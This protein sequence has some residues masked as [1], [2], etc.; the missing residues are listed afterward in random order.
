MCGKYHVDYFTA[1]DVAK[2]APDRNGVINSAIGEN[3]GDIVPSMNALVV[4]GN[5]RELSPDIM[6]WGFPGFSGSRLLINARAETALEKKTFS[7][8]VLN[9]R[10]V[11]PAKWFYE[12]DRDRNMA[13]FTLEGHSTI[14]LAGF[15]DLFDLENRYVI[16][17][18]AANES[19]IRTHDRMPLLI[20][21]TDIRDWIHDDSA[22][23][24]FLGAVQPQLT[25]KQ[26]FEQLTFF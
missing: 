15:Y 21:E 17:T 4:R 13:V 3:G 23:K 10:C 11:I 5:G 16:L 26:E 9:R 2:I 1:D 24:D 8:S 18:T 22:I 25:K 12:W 7:D 6:R 19:M 20:S 14:Y